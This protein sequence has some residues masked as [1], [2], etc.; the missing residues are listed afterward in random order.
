MVKINNDYN[1]DSF[2][3]EQE[4]VLDGEPL[5]DYLE[6]FN[7]FALSKLFFCYFLQ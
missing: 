4:E 2:I 3:T 5:L 1:E 7:Q 6:L